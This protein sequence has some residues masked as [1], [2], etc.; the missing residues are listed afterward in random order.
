MN[1]RTLQPIPGRGKQIIKTVKWEEG[2]EGGA[3]CVSTKGQHG[4]VWDSTCL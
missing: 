2:S 3:G 1:E 4:S